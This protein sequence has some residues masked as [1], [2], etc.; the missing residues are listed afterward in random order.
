MKKKSTEAVPSVVTIIV[1]DENHKYLGHGTGFIIISYALTEEERMGIPRITETPL[2]PNA[3]ALDRFD[4]LKTLPEFKYCTS[5]IVTNY[6]VV[7]LGYKDPGVWQKYFY[8]VITSDGTELPETQSVVYDQAAISNPHYDVAL[9]LCGEE[10]RL[11]LPRS[12]VKGFNTEPNP[13]QN[14]IVIGSPKDPS[15]SNSIT[16]GIV[17][18]SSR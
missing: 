15:L 8:T 13:G 2:P 4:H 3:S 7:S 17:L 14:V 1:K 18:G 11:D 16:P 12:K 5:I 9:L 6:H 10:G